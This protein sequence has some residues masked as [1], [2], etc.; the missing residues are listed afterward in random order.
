MRILYSK[1]IVSSN[2]IKAFFP[3]NTFL[4]SFQVSEIEL[5]NN[6][7]MKV[8]HAHRKKTNKT[9]W[10]NKNICIEELSNNTSINFLI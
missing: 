3:F 6:D 4:L 5:K 1:K 10:S 2:Y 9:N 8:K 7:V